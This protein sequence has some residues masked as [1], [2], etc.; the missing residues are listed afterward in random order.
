MEAGSSHYTTKLA[1]G[2]N[3]G[4]KTSHYKAGAKKNRL[5]GNRISSK[6]K[7]ISI[8]E[9]VQKRTRG[10]RGTAWET[11]SRTVAHTIGGLKIN[12]SKKKKK[13]EERGHID[14]KREKNG[15]T[16]RI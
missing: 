13:T 8:F 2:Q 3:K 5:R 11:A 6:H 10:G 16:N 9:L 12:L 7:S 15:V 1:K 14:S 4:H